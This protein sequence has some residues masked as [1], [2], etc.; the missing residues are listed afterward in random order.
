MMSAALA[1]RYLTGLKEPISQN[2][3]VLERFS[4]KKKCFN[5]IIL[6]PSY[7]QSH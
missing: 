1:T 5:A 4:T 2:S 7:T 3:I 6:T